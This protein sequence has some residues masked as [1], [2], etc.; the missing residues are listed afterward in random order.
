MEAALA[1]GAARVAVEEVE[2]AVEVTAAAMADVA[3]V[4]NDTWLERMVPRWNLGC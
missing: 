1:Q 2:V 3:V 4:A